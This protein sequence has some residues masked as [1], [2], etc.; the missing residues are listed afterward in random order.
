MPYPKLKKCFL[1]GRK[2]G[3]GLPRHEIDIN[4]N[5]SVV[6]VEYY[7][8]VHPTGVN[9]LP[10]GYSLCPIGYSLLAIPYF[11]E[12]VPHPRANVILDELF[13]YKENYFQGTPQ[14]PRF[15]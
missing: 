9:I 10:I 6:Y 4:I 13:E 2:W 8:F 12:V 7:Q 14:K 5:R 3:L 1:R 11:L 15:D